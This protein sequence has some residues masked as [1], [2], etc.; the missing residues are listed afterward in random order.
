MSKKKES[1]FKVHYFH[2]STIPLQQIS[3]KTPKPQNPE[4][5]KNKLE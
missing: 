1:F 2:V 4:I 5:V 3:P